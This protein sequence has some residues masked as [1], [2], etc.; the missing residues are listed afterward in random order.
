MTEPV[1]FLPRDFVQTAEGLTF[2]VVAE[3]LEDGRVRCFLRYAQQDGQ[4]CKL[5]TDTANRLLTSAYPEYLFHSNQLDADLHAVPTQAI[6]RHLKPQ[7]RLRQLLSDGPRDPIEERLC[8]LVQHFE[9]RGLNP[10][11]FGVTGSILAAAHGAGSD[12]D[13][14]VYGRE[15]FHQA[16]ETLARMIAEGRLQCMDRHAWER[17]YQRRGCSLS[18]EEYLWHERRKYNK[19]L[20]DGTKFDLAMVVTT[21]KDESKYRKCKAL[22]IRVKVSDDRHAFDYPARYAVDGAKLDEVVCFTATYVGQAR[23]GEIVEASGTLEV[24]D[25]G[26][27]RLVIGSTREAQGEYLKVVHSD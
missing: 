13:L 4:R 7:Q 22:R 3:G 16:R 1:A 9:S 5:A 26:Q 19:A 25:Q 17:A 18:F 24:S 15:I 11:T 21:P 2:A 27:R 20:I 10:A 14:V 8:R 23:C 6:V 12:I